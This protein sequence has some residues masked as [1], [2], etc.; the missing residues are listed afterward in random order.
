MILLDFSKAFDNVPYR[1]L[2]K[3]LHNY[4]IHGNTDEWMQAFITDYR[5]RVVVDGDILEWAPVESGAS[6]GTVLGHILFL[7]FINILS[8][9]YVVKCPIRLFTDDAVMYRKVTSSK[10]CDELQEDI[11]QLEK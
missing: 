10:D 1:H 3:I 4:E 9:V 11:H 5:P 6:Q 7:A 8:S 2:M